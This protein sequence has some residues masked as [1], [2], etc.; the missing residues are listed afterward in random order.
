LT[1]EAGARLGPYEIV[2]PLGRG[3]MGEV[4]KAHDTR[5]GRH[6]A[7]KVL[8]AAVAGDAELRRRLE[9]EAR[10]VSRLQHP[11]ICT[12]HDIGE[13]P[14][15][16]P[17]GEG[18]S[19][20]TPSSML[21]TIRFLVLEYLEGDSLEERLHRGPLPMA[22]VLRCGREIAE[23]L[24]AAH[25]AGVVH[26]DLKPGNVM[27]TKMGAK[28]L[29]FGVARAFRAASA[30]GAPAASALAGDHPTLTLEHTTEGRLIGTLPY[31]APEQLE[32]RDADART[33][34]WALG[35]VLHEMATG[36][37][38]FGGATPASLIASILAAAPKPPSRRR[39]LA[40]ERL[41]WVVKRCLEKDPERRWQS[42]RDVGIELEEIAAGVVQSPPAM[43]AAALDPAATATAE[44]GR[45]AVD[46]RRR[47]LGVLWAAATLAVILLAAGLWWTRW[48]EPDSSE[49]VAALLEAFHASDRR[50]AIAPFEN[51]SG[52]A[53]LDPL[54][55]GI[56]AEMI[57]VSAG[58][59][60]GD[61]FSS[62]AG[63]EA[64]EGR[65]VCQLAEGPLWAYGG[66]VRRGGSELRITASM[67]A[68]P[69]GDVRW[70]QDYA[71]GSAEDPATLVDDLVRRIRAES[72]QTSNLD[73]GTPGSL[74][75]FM[76][77]RTHEATRKAIE[78][79]ETGLARDSGNVSNLGALFNV[80]L[81]LLIEG[82]ADPPAESVGAL[83]TAAEAWVAH[84][85]RDWGGHT[86][87]GFAGLFAGDREQMLRGFQRARDLAPHVPATHA[88]LGNALCIAGRSDEAL[89]ELR[90]AFE[91][92]PEDVAL[93][94][95]ISFEA[96][97]H[98]V[99]GRLEEARAAAQ[100]GIDLNAN[101]LFNARATL[102][103]RLAASEALLGRPEEARLALAESLRLRPALTLEV[104][105]WRLRAADAEPRERYLEGLRI[106]G[107]GASA[108][109]VTARPAASAAAPESPTR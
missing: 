91:M 81:Q 58:T 77:Q 7:I 63:L 28:V 1:V 78:I 22:D 17:R 9:R 40:P 79:V 72:Q 30:R 52:E 3:G 80:H 100:R 96:W 107:L 35:C 51:L 85:P 25:R 44:V 97:A 5:L 57:G 49:D 62:V 89:R 37:R 105:G 31:M 21:A 33:D 15:P 102:Y 108:V 68:C 92:S 60:T 87:L 67:T 88:W 27:M 14:M 36:E 73:R 12:L 74:R 53:A 41:D 75:W 45:N 86:A 4:Y 94:S 24:E 13:E 104:A 2:E 6:V 71:Y 76:S 46:P 29:D 106:A 103:E 10:T 39:P 11:H 16:S 38:P 84:A 61:A 48:P 64:T 47:R 43:T 93:P 54:I 19:A 50:F 32:G 109:P 42:A 18:A 95:W 66:T 83:R 56:S 26:R 99:S 20:E 82:W 90:I 65:G 59:A 8:P 70:S 34:I 69:E 55:D 98:F 101:E 23:A